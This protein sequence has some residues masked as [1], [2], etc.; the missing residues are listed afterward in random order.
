MSGIRRHARP[1]TTYEQHSNTSLIKW[2]TGQITPAGYMI[3]VVLISRAAG[4][5]NTGEN[6]TCTRKHDV[7]CIFFLF[8]LQVLS[9]SE[10]LSSKG[11]QETCGEAHVSLKA[12]KV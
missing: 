1:T 7:I 8:A 5:T 11:C 10:R 3:Q 2:L 12:F 6:G 4:K 9:S